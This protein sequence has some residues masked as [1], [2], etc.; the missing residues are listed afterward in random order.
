MSHES[1]G[2]AMRRGL[3]RPAAAGTRTVLAILCLLVLTAAGAADALAGTLARAAP[4]SC[5]TGR[6]YTLGE[7]W[8]HVLQAVANLR[9]TPPTDPLIVLLGDS[10]AREAT[11]SD[12]VWTA[13]IEQAG[14]PHAAAYN[15]SSRNRTLAENVALVRKLPDVPTVVVVG[16]SLC[17]FTS[18]K[19]SAVIRLPTP[20][21]TLPPYTQHPYGPGSVLPDAQKRKLAVSWMKTRYPVFRRNADSCARVLSR[22]VGV[23]RERGFTPVL[24][25]MPLNTAVIGHRFDRPVTRYRRA[26][27]AVAERW[28]VPFVRVLARAGLASGG[29]ADLWHLVEPGRSVCQGLISAQSV[30]LL[31]ALPQDLARP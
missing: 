22:L 12:A 20:T 23:C 8:N 7:D 29:F 15:L 4:A 10:I 1:V 11:E 2:R 3:P 25:E 19:T 16:V 21:A 6:A 9:A 5:P 27:R 24:L 28:D 31:R 26:C 13:Q 14:G 30:P 18:P 17:S